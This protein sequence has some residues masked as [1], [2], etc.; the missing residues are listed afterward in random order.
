MQDIRV[1]LLKASDLEDILEFERIN[2]AWFES[3]IQPRGD[4]FFTQNGVLEHVNEC[5]LFYKC[6]TMLPLV[7]RNAL[8]HLIARV[9]LHCLDVNKKSAL[10]G[11]RVD[12]REVGKGIA[13]AASYHIISMAKREYGINNFV[14]IVAKNNIASQ[15]VLAKNG[16][17]RT[18]SF[19]K[20]AKI[21]GEYVD[22]YE[23]VLDT[24]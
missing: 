14:A 17:C 23:Y 3:Q 22:C 18:R 15:K 2:K 21:S 1:E 7:V 8:G 16:F 5:L 11:Y 4:Q 20:Y 12:Q 19:Q 10:L 6:Q 13:S 9:N 24:D